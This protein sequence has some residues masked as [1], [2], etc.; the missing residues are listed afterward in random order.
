MPVEK[1]NLGPSPAGDHDSY[2][3]HVPDL[4]PEKPG[5]QRPDD[6]V[7]AETAAEEEPID[8]WRAVSDSWVVAELATADADY[9]AGNT[10]SGDELRRRFGLS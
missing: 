1:A 3:L 8:D 2:H 4:L 9:A 7:D 5:E 10:I 6:D